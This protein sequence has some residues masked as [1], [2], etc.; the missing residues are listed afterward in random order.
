[1]ILSFAILVAP[2]VA[3][4]ASLIPCGGKD[5]DPCEFKHLIKLANTIIRFLMIDV[6][7]P[8]AAIGFMWTGG[9]LILNQNK[10]GAWNDAKS[11]FSDIG[12][13]FGIMLGAFVLIKFI[14]FAFLSDE[15]ATFVNFIIE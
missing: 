3:F 9:N 10:E 8:L 12:M 5:Q 4:G 15:Q 7:V 14:L 2:S 6:A 11:S 13:G 1:M